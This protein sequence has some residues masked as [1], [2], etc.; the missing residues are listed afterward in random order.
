VLVNLDLDG[1]VYDFE[2]TMRAFVEAELGAAN[3]PVPTRWHVW[4]DWGMTVQE[5]ERAFHGAVEWG[6][7]GRGLPVDGAIEGVKTL[8]EEGHQVR[9]VTHKVLESKRAT[10]IAMIDVVDWLGAYDLV[11]RVDLAMVRGHKQAYTADV[12]V[13][14]KPAV[15]EWA[16]PGSLN[17]VFDQPWNQTLTPRYW[18]DRTTRAYGW[19]N[20]LSLIRVEDR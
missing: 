3:L 20:L 14:D 19:E 5:W 15:H 16:Q 7:F 4:E 11:H 2:G 6:V 9:F 17:V 12:V 13:D 8:L 18:T 1:V 10:K